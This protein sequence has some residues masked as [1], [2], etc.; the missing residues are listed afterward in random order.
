MRPIAPAPDKRNHNGSRLPEGRKKTT[1]GQPS[2][3]SPHGHRCSQHKAD[4]S[5]RSE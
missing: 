1:A 5:L 4:S 2:R 3:L